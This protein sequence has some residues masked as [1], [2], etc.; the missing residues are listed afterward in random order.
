MG[1]GWRR[2]RSDHG[3]FQ[4]F[5]VARREPGMIRDL[6]EELASGVARAE[7]VRASSHIPIAQEVVQRDEGDIVVE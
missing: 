2:K 1:R 5:A 6:R 4:R 3:G 7:K